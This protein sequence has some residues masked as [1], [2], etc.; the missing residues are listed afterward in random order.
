MEVVIMASQVLGNGDYI[1]FQYDCRGTGPN[2]T[3]DYECNVDYDV[4]IQCRT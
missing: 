1:N 3:S 2:F 4:G